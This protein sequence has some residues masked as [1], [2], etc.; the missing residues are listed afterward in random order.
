MK[1]G[2]LQFCLHGPSPYPIPRQPGQPQGLGHQTSLV[3]R[4]QSRTRLFPTRVPGNKGIMGRS[5]LLIA[6]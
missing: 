5:R 3:T 1:G 2:V 4:A 6:L